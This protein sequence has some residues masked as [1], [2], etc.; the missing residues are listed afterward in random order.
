MTWSYTSPFLGMPYLLPSQAQKHVTVNEALSVLDALAQ[1]AVKN[2]TLTAPPGG[3]AEGDRH[4]VAAP[5][6]GAWSGKE[7]QIAAFIDG[8][9]SVDEIAGTA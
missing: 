8:G 2:R 9:A 6:T 4:I 7:E 3:P 1:L 5:A